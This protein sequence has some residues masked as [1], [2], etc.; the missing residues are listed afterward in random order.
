M[1]DIEGVERAISDI[2][3]GRPVI[4]VDDE[5]RENEGDLIFAAEKATPELLAFMVRYTSGYICVPLTEADCDRLDLPPMFHTN[6]DRRGTAYTVTVDA[7]EGVSTGISAADRARTIRLLADSKSV[8]GDF[9]RPGHVVP[10]RA[11]EGGVL[12]RPGHTE[13]AIDLAVLAGLRPAGVLCEIVSQKDEGDMARREELE[14][15][16]AEHDLTIISIADLIDYRRRKEVQVVR[17]AEARIPTAHGAFRAVGYDSKLDGIEHIALVYG[18]IE[19][20][21]NVLVRVHSECLTG[22]VFGSL[23][24]DCGPQLEAALAAVAAEG[25]GVVL[26]MRGH[27]GRGIGLMHKLQAYQLQDDGADTVDA[28]LMQG[29]PAD[30]RDYGQGAQILVDLGIKSMRLLT[31]N[32]AKRVGLD[33]YGLTIVDRVALPIRPNAENLRYLRTKRDRMGHEL[34]DLDL[35]EGSTTQ[36]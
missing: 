1:T 11:K 32:P 5:D 27:E 24:C 35:F 7:R 16:A 21:E 10:L 14:V 17:V 15:F 30:A 9:T 36:A 3:A 18:D 6:Q 26:Y 33:G 8:A 13:A 25:R 34:G 29:M 12:R 19:D 4:V 22:D 31:N 28:N 20:G 2:A 23:R